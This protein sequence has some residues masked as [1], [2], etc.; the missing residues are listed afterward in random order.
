M[1]THGSESYYVIGE[2]LLTSF[3]QACPVCEGRGVVVDHSI[4][5]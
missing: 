3:A 4:I 1:V 2:G 5:E